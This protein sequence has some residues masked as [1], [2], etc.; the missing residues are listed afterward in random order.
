MSTAILVPSDGDIL[1]YSKTKG[2]RLRYQQTIGSYRDLRDWLSWHQD[3]ELFV[4]AGSDIDSN[5][6]YEA[7]LRA[8]VVTVPDLWLANLPV[9]ATA[10]RAREAAR[11]ARAH[12]RRPLNVKAAATPKD[13]RPHATT[14]F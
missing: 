10:R 1:L 7:L 13:L 6:L 8:D 4:I 11:I 3:L 14:P 2:T 9:N 5:Y 12:R